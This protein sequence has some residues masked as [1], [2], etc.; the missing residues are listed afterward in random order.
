MCRRS[1]C[2]CSRKNI[3]E[4]AAEAGAGNTAWC[5]VVSKYAYCH[6]QQEKQIVFKIHDYLLY[7]SY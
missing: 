6:H 5:F 7:S 1:V 2:P 4:A 3:V